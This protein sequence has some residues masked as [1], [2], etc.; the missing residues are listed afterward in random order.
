MDGTFVAVWNDD[1]KVT[2]YKDELE[3]ETAVVTLGWADYGWAGYDGYRW[4]QES[5]VKV[6]LSEV[7]YSVANFE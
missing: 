4:Y 1:V 2:L 3:S 5:N 6:P 7:G